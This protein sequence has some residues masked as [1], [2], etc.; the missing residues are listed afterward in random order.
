MCEKALNSW[1]LVNVNA[2]SIQ[3]ASHRLLVCFTQ[4]SIVNDRR[5]NLFFYLN[6]HAIRHTLNAYTTAQHRC[7]FSSHFFL[8]LWALKDT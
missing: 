2:S 3:M 4:T 6:P 8:Y 1:M 7:T 5:K